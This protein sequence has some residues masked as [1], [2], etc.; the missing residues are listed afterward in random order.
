MGHLPF[1]SAHPGGQATVRAKVEKSNFLI[2]LTFRERRRADHRIVSL[3]L[4]AERFVALLETTLDAGRSGRGGAG[5][6]G[7]T[8]AGRAGA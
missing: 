2:L 7:L 1:S 6:D 8:G 3:C 4:I 5:R